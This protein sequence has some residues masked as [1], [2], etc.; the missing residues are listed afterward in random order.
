[1]TD[2]S[3]GKIYKIV[4]DKGCYIGSTTQ[5]L[6]RRFQKHEAD[7][8]L[9]NRKCSSSSIMENSKII[10][11]EDYPCKTRKELLERERYWIENIEC[12]NKERPIITKEE[13]KEYVKN[14]H[15]I[16]KDHK[17]Q[18]RREWRAF[19]RTWGFNNYLGTSLNLLD[20]DVNLFN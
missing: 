20:I 14:W 16:N 6:R 5:T 12:V 9:N 15:V 19:K 17:N 4:S 7:L 13:K 3:R 11:I 8:K 10:L 18:Y 2:Y 1:M